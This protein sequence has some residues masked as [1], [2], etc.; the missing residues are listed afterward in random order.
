MTD[1]GHD[2]LRCV[3]STLV[4]TL[5]LGGFIRPAVG[6]PLLPAISW[7]V[8]APAQ[9]EG[10]PTP[11]PGENSALPAENVFPHPDRV[12][13]RHLNDARELA[14]QSRYGE[15][16]RCLDAILNSPE[17]YLFQ[18]DERRPSHRSLRLEANRILGRMPRAGRE[19]YELQFGSEARRLLERAVASRDVDLLA[20][21]SRRFFHTAAGYE[22]TFLLGLHYLDG[23]EPLTA[24]LK[25][26]QVRDESLS[27]DRFEPA[28]SLSLATCWYRAGFPEQAEEVLRRLAERGSEATLSIGG[29]D[30]RWLVDLEQL[31]EELSAADSIGGVEPERSEWLQARG[32]ASRNAVVSGSRP[33]LDPVW[34]ASLSD[35]PVAESLLANQSE[36]QALRNT[37]MISVLQPLAL[38]DVVVMR[39]LH[40]LMAIDPATGKRLWEAPAEDVLEEATEAYRAMFQQPGHFVGYV[41][42][43]AWKDQVYGSLSSDGRRVFAVEDL[44]VGVSGYGRRSVV[45]GGRRIVNPLWPKS[46]NRLAAYDARGGKLLWH[47]GGSS[48]EFDLDL[49]GA[50][51]LGAPLPVGR[52]LY[53]LADVSGEIRLYCLNAETGKVKWS[54]RIAMTDQGIVQSPTRRWAS[55]SPSCG[56]GIL[57]CPT[58]AGAIVAVEPGTPSLLWGYRYSRSPSASDSRGS[59]TPFPR[60]QEGV[61]EWIDG[62]L[63]VS[64]DRA[65]ATPPDSDEIHCLNLLDGSALWKRPR[66]GDIYLAAVQGDN[67]VLVGPK[68]VRALSLKTGR[69]SWEGR[70]LALPEGSV[71]SG[72]GAHVGGQYYLPLS[73]AEMLVFDLETGRVLQRSASSSGTVPGNL[74]CHGDKV[75]S[76]SVQG[77]AA[78]HQIEALDQQVEK[79]LAQDADDAEAWRLKGRILID[80][81]KHDEAIECLRRSYRLSRQSLCRI[82]L[83]E[84]LLDGLRRDFAQYR[85]A[86]D[87]IRELLDAR[88]D[89]VSFLCLMA[90]GLELESEWEPALEYYLRLA[91]LC[92]DGREMIEIDAAHLVRQDRWVRARLAGL[93]E[94]APSAVVAR[95]DAEVQRRLEAV[96][97]REGIEPLARFVECFGDL[98]VS[99][100][101]RRELIGRYS[102]SKEC[103]AADLTLRRGARGS[104]PAAAAVLAHRLARLLED[105]GREADAATYY[106]EL[107]ERWGDVA[108]H[109][110][111]TGQE[112]VASLPKDSAASAFPRPERDWPVGA[113]EVANRQSEPRP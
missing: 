94:I 84:A 61:N 92:E 86:V 8:L 19:A 38:D 21:V 6:Q 9:V 4:S 58:A 73:T 79:R 20:G 44:S 80:E 53:Q 77:V 109:D 32:N 72:Q 64:K 56:N 70:T 104:D 96:L 81:G 16:V 100:S 82:Q 83:R 105:E 48:D 49:T 35:H 99:E 3:V 106:R 110:G 65:L 50:F 59:F 7:G 42:Q 39:S 113:V 76:Q 95:M 93:R 33:L 75:I 66:G 12:L 24:A 2:R 25:L 91:D 45:R 18:P 88:R 112:I 74:I 101:A 40:T 62:H 60:N 11:E 71:P 97:G 98:P 89:E 29:R 102:A 107:E 41:C 69:P 5:A 15:A 43:R 68:Q 67:V 78:F 30:K 90:S 10:Q 23:R 34:E 52:Q 22:A 28:L 87:E 37:P 103:L 31:R 1:V 55:L 85:S 36:Y 51:F 17:D 47:L 46:F 63:I 54:Q 27:A 111:K 13:L 14:E 57:V 108:C 26:E